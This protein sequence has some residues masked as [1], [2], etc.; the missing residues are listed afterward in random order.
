MERLTRIRREYSVAGNSFS[1][2]NAISVRSVEDAS[3]RM[4]EE[5]RN[6]AA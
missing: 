3:L 5:E 2:A 4:A 1:H 6:H